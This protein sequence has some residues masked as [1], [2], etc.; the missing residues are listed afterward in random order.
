[1]TLATS[2]AAASAAGASLDDTR[3]VMLCLLVAVAAVLISE[4]LRTRL[5]VPAVVLEVAGGILI[6]PDVLG[7]AHDTPLVSAL[8]GLGLAVLMF[9]AGYELQLSRVRG[10][11][12]RAASVGWLVS[13]ALGLLAGA[14]LSLVADAVGELTSGLV[15]GLALTT[16]ALGTILP[17]VRDAGDLDTDFGRYVLATGAVG[18]F[19]PILAV[20]V[21]LSGQKPLRTAA[22]L[23]LFTAVAAAALVVAA[24]PP[25]RPRLHRVVQRT[26]ETSG[27]LAVRLT[28]LLVLFLVWVAGTLGLDVLLGA[29][30]AGVVART[31]LSGA[32]E[33]TEVEAVHRLEGIGF[34]FVIP[35]FFV[36]SGIRFDAAALLGDPGTLL[37]LPVFLGLFLLVR[38]VPSAWSVRAALSPAERGPLLLYASTTLPLVVVITTIGVD[39]G[40]LPTAGAAALVGAAMLSVLLLPLLALRWRGRSAAL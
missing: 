11:P 27:Q 8:S 40:T 9:L 16:T 7:L 31:F 33:E 29:F 6:G 38:G 34:G 25:R 37:L 4:L 10:G 2:A 5:P 3:T 21:L 1:M 35:V 14:L 18:E 15:L 32:A 12:L 23:L 28:M 13:L 20:A 30:A 17:I 19:G 36:V 22:V 39:D 24:R 26:L